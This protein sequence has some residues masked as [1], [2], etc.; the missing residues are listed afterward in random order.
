MAD[1]HRQRN[2]IVLSI[3]FAALAFEACSLILQPI[4]HPDPEA[5]TCVGSDLDRFM[6]CF[7]N[8]PGDYIDANT[9]QN[10]GTSEYCSE[11]AISGNGSGIFQSPD[12][13]LWT[14]DGV[15]SDATTASIE[16]NEMANFPASMRL[17]VATGEDKVTVETF[18]EDGSRD[19]VFEFFPCP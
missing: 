4:E 6:G 19:R 8:R 15:L 12:T 2:I 11:F 13:G 17:S 16:N 14:F 10:L 1:N 18:H 9:Y 7:G 3:A 5:P